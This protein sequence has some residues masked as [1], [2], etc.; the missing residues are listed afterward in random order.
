M[1]DDVFRTGVCMQADFEHQV[2]LERQHNTDLQRQNEQLTQAQVYHVALDALYEV[3]C[4][5]CP[6]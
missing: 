1:G 3:C 5:Q 2:K 6:P 4:T